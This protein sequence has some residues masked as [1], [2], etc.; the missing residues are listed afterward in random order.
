MVRGLV[1]RRPVLPPA[2]AMAVPAPAAVPA[3]AAAAEVAA[4]VAAAAVVVAAVV[5]DG[6]AYGGS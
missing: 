2:V 4:V 6:R 3:V 5:A 1:V